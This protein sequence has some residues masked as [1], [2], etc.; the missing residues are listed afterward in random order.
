MIV[1]IPD[2]CLL[3]TFHVTNFNA[4]NTKSRHKKHINRHIIIVSEICIGFIIGLCFGDFHHWSDYGD[5]K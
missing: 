2:H 3:L 4:R 1:L 5:V